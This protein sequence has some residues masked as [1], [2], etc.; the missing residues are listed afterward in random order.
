MHATIAEH[1]ALDC[2]I[3]G[4]HR[5]NNISAGS[6]RHFGGPIRSL[7]HQRFG[8]RRSAVVNRDFVA[9]LAADSRHP[10]THVS[11]ANES[12][13]H[14]QVLQSEISELDA[15]SS[16]KDSL[17]AT[18][19][20]RLP[21]FVLISK[22]FS[23]TNAALES[24]YSS[25]LKAAWSSAPLTSGFYKRP[26]VISGEGTGGLLIC[27]INSTRLAGDQCF[28]LAQMVQI[29]SGHHARHMSDALVS[30]LFVHTVVVP[31]SLR[32]RLQQSHIRGS[33][34]AK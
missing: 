33:Q 3:I 8:F 7:L 26:S 16:A 34:D 24:L 9:S 13:F 22:R 25:C 6:I 14:V 20:I 11:Q 31:E 28:D 12:N 10:D 21:I 27:R 30:A 2:S 15:R 4:K 23:A 5:D 17:P 19:R 18:G 32:N 1:N 29:V